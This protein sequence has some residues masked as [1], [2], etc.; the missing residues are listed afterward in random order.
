MVTHILFQLD[1]YSGTKERGRMVHIV[2]IGLGM[3]KETEYRNSRT[4]IVL[5]CNSKACTKCN[6]CS[7]YEAGKHKGQRDKTVCP[8]MEVAGLKNGLV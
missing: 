5:A 2:A 8:E 4:D 6:T 3:T 1:Q 7:V